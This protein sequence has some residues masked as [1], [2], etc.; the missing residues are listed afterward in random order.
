M[1]P[2]S[3]PRW[4]VQ[5]VSEGC[6]SATD[7]AADLAAADGTAS[8]LR[9]VRRPQVA[10]DISLYQV[11]PPLQHS[12]TCWLC[13]HSR[14]IAL[15]TRYAARCTWILGDMGWHRKQ[16]V[17]TVVV[18]H[19]HWPTNSVPFSVLAAACISTVFAAGRVERKLR[20]PLARQGLRRSAGRTGRCGKPGVRR[21]ANSCHA[22]ARQAQDGRGKYLRAL[23]G[24]Q[25][26]AAAH[27]VILCATGSS[28]RS[29]LASCFARCTASMAGPCLCVN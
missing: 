6:A 26:L 2:A 13:H 28:P 3:P 19:H 14:L 20:A 22:E 24:A 10:V 23:P 17:C 11:R 5:P 4:P 8:P 18:L 7:A 27:S 15:L 25:H 21:I 16:D 29:A 12:L 9:G 1:G